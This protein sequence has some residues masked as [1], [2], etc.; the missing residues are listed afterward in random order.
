MR[1]L[2]FLTNYGHDK[3]KIKHKKQFQYGTEFLPPKQII[4]KVKIH[5]LQPLV[6]N[7]PIIQENLS[8]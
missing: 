3:V 5:I 6:N 8:F 4:Q 7:K 1:K 2:I